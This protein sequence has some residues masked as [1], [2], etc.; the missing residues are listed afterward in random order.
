MKR[1]NFNIKDRRI[2][3][4]GLC[5]ILICIFTLSIAYAALNAVLT[6]QGS[7]EVSA[8][9]WDI[10]LENPI[11]TSGSVNRNIPTISDNTL[12]FSAKLTKP[13]EY[14]EFTVDVVNAGS[15]DAMIENVVKTPELSAEQAKYLKYEVSYENG[16]NINT[17]QILSKGSR[18]PIKV[19]IEYRKDLNASDLPNS[20]LSLNLQLTLVYMQSDGSG[21]VVVDNGNYIDLDYP[22]GKEICFDSEC[23]YVISSSPDFVT[24]LSKY[25]LYVGNRCT[26]ITADS[27]DCTDY[28]AAATGKQD[29]NM[30]KTGSTAEGSVQFSN[31]TKQ[32]VYFNS[33]EGSIVQEY[34]EGYESYLSTLISPLEVRLISKSELVDLG[35]DYSKYTCA[36]A[37]EWVTS[38]NYWGETPSTSSANQYVIS[39]L[40]SKLSGYFVRSYAF[41][42]R[43]V[44]VV[45]KDQIP[46][47]K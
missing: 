6:I 16:D 21:N 7:A 46:D 32:G 4:L 3:T 40:G 24:M 19:R 13:G 44:V 17:K 18:M 14:Y 22:V 1:I 47:S 10:H 36:G 15:I 43:P 42:V 29:P 11:V 2:L 38:R 35:C 31:A 8:A 26:N 45:S 27:A 12:S 23:F 34:V 28:G 9:N 37:P 39:V 20:S 5:L 33:Y 25:N 41:G 30:I